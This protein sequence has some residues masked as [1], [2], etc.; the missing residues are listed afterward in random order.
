MEITES[1]AKRVQVV[2]VGGGF[3]GVA[4]IRTLRFSGVSCDITLVTKGERFEYFP[5]LY[6][7]VTGALAIEVSVPYTKMKGWGGV[8]VEKGIFTGV[9][10]D[11]RRIRLEDGRELPYDYLV[12]A[13]GSETNYFGIKGLAEL[14]LSFKSV[15][16]ASRLKKHFC[17]VM[18]TAAGLPKNEAVVKLH[19][20]IVG[21]GP[22]GVELAGDLTHYLRSLA[23][24]MGV[25]PS[26]VTIDLIES[27]PRIL[28]AL[29][30]AASRSA[31]KRLRTLG[32]NIYPNRAVAGQDIFSVSTG[33]MNF[34]SSTVIWTAGTK[35]SDAFTAIPGA[36]LSDK[37]RVTVNEFLALPDDSRVFIAGDGA[38]TPK[39]GLAQT[40]DYDGK[41]LGRTL[42]RLIVGKRP[43]PYKPPRVS[44]VIPVG[45]YWALFVIGK[46]VFT[47]FLPWLLRS[48]ADFRY[49]TSIVPLSYVFDV[50]RQGRKYRQSQTYCPLE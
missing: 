33:S 4:A 39:S 25:D 27:A 30:E 22:S 16:E 32:V 49:F 11:Q 14:S 43:S 3:A 28:A 42:A 37:R 26:L 24:T 18:S 20:I 34:Q 15:K 50:Y 9:D 29:P 46:R 13:L 35:I 19:T 2:I 21:G 7:L 5:A 47:G 23:K 8:K 12:L 41:Y 40:A 44:F 10:R 38:S 17:D 48:A 45:N 1:A 6:K 31:E 36:S